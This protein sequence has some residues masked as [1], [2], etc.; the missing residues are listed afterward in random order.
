MIWR[1][2]I[3]TFIWS[4]ISGQ[5]VISINSKNHN[6]NVTSTIE[7][8]KSS[9][10]IINFNP[11]FER[12]KIFKPKQLN[13]SVQFPADNLTYYGR[14]KVINNSNNRTTEVFYIANNFLDSIYF[15]QTTNDKIVSSGWS[16]DKI[17]LN[18]HQFKNRL[19]IFQFNM[20]PGDTSEIL[21]AFKENRKIVINTYIIDVESF[22]STSVRDHVF[23]GVF[24]G[25]MCLFSLIGFV[26]YFFTKKPYF[27]YYACLVLFGALS[28]STSNGIWHRFFTGLI[29]EASIIIHTVTI[30]I[31][32]VSSVLF[33]RD[34][35]DF[36]KVLPR[37][38][39]WINI[40]IILQIVTATVLF[41]LF[42][43][44][45]LPG[46]TFLMYIVILISYVIIILFLFKM[47]KHNRMPS[48]LMIFYF[49]PSF[50][51][52]F[53]YSWLRSGYSHNDFLIN[54]ILQFTSLSL[55]MV[56]TIAIGFS[57]KN[58]F[59][60]RIKLLDD[61]SQQEK[62]FNSQIQLQ[63]EKQQHKI[64]NLLHDSFGVKLRHIKTL[65]EGSRLQEAKS[66]ILMFAS[67]MRDISHSMSPTILDHLFLWEAVQD[68]A[69]KYS[70]NTL[71][72][73]VDSNEW[74][75][76]LN[77]NIKIILY[78]IIQECISNTVKYA[79]ANLLSIQLEKT[80][81]EILLTI[82]DDG[83]GTN[84]EEAFYNGIGL[85]TIK[86]RIDSLGGECIMDSSPNKGF[87]CVIK[88]LSRELA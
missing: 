63:K 48:I 40:T 22:A 73:I 51:G 8:Y 88:V 68:L 52:I 31:W 61:L 41:T 36:K 4:G 46:L 39:Y 85:K 55:I 76:E 16:G 57:I 58:E 6:L 29:P 53:I 23:I 70:S 2:I 26:A 25:I 69:K 3:I 79:D 49:I 83:Q 11:S 56:V 75:N 7:Y 21:I 1:L 38:F 9:E 77:K 67:E 84:I 59:K 10:A 78:N 50:A 71:N 20:N 81:D 66:E 37:Q 27:L 24:Y 65:I 34:F 64:A 43:T 42:I 72:I 5:D 30:S 19:N 28:N 86:S 80:S 54:F 15:Q 32:L 35:L 12:E 62:L 45:D 47:I 13:K 87:L 74:E 14:L 33:T 17:N 44:L 60:L 18:R 82:E